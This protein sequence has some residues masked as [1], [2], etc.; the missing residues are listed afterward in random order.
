MGTPAVAISATVLPSSS[1]RT[2]A[3]VVVVQIA[4]NAAIVDVAHAVSTSRLH[5]PT[6]RVP[7]DSPKVVAVPISGT[8]TG[9]MT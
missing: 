1:T 3:S 8:R 4:P 5:E 6:P 9:G 7:A 2:I